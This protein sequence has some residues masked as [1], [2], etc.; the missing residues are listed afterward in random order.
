MKKKLLWRFRFIHMVNTFMKI[1]VNRLKIGDWTVP[2]ITP[3]KL[4]EQ[5]N[6]NQS[7]LLLYVL[8]IYGEE[9]LIPKAKTI[10]TMK[11][12]SYLDRLEP[13][14]EKKIVTVCGGGGMSLVAADILI[15]AGFKDVKSLNG[16]MELWKKR[17][18]PTSK[19]WEQAK[20][21]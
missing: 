19:P 21:N 1:G 17:G 9:G 20:M 14:K 5:I 4:N 13:Y 3:E 11:L 10:P 18:F 6:A 12:V 2:E 15:Q 16:G 7:P 8:R